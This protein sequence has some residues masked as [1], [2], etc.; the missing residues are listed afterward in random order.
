[1]KSPRTAGTIEASLAGLDHS[2]MLDL[3]RGRGFAI[4]DLIASFDHETGQYDTAT[5]VRLWMKHPGVPEA[6]RA[7]YESSPT[8]PSGA[9]ETLQ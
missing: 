2:A 8:A 4:S 6:F 7:R 3:R 1:M 5:F 9:K